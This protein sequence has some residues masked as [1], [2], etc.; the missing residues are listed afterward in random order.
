[1]NF[2]SVSDFRKAAA[3]KFALSQ[4]GSFVLAA[5]LLFASFALQVNHSTLSYDEGIARYVSVKHLE[6][7]TEG[8]P[9]VQIYQQL[10]DKQHGPVAPIVW[11]RDHGM[12][13]PLYFVVINL[14]TRLIPIN[15]SLLLHLPNFAFALLALFFIG[16][17]SKELLGE[18]HGIVFIFLA[19][20]PWFFGFTCF[21]RPYT[22]AILLVICSTWLSC[23]FQKADKD[24][25]KAAIAYVI[26][27]A[28]GL[29]R[30]TILSLLSSGNSFGTEWQLQDWS[31]S[32]VV[33]NG[34]RL[35]S[36]RWVLPCYSLPG[37]LRS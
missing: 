37:F 35:S 22:L 2:M 14:W 18:S 25:H 20:S 7:P 12:H 3:Q 31:Q 5:L 4:S 30:T 29:Y 17:L 1:M 6:I 36:W 16:K 21:L 32:G 33:L 24:T 11:Q 13:P 9:V 34:E 26:V 8:Q 10:N 15:N 19:I 23:L 27:G 28:L